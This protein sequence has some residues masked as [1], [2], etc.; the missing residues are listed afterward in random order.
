MLEKAYGSVLKN[1]LQMQDEGRSILPIDIITDCYDR[2]Q[3]VTG[4][5]GIPVDK[6]AAQ[7]LELTRGQTLRTS[8]QI[9][10]LAD[11]SD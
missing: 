3:F 4:M 7:Y 1:L 2:F 6:T 8:S 11:G 9:L 10:S 5:K